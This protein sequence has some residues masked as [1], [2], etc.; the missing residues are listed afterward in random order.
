MDILAHGLWVSV[1]AQALTQ[2]GQPVSTRGAIAWGIAPD[3]VAF[4]PLFGFLLLGVVDGN[5]TWAQFAN[6]ESLG[7]PSLNGHPIF[8][9]TAVLYSLGHS[10]VV[11]AAV[12]AI[13]CW[14][15]RRPCW[16]MGGWGLHILLDI[17]THTHDFYPT[18]FL[19]PLLDWTVNGISWTE[20]WM[21][22]LN[23]IAILMSWAWLA[24][25]SPRHPA[26]GR[27]R[28]KDG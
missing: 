3:L 10:A 20:T 8:P 12:L 28:P 18:P 11:F 9:L 24:T 25:M 6:P 14:W 13:A 21:L 4:T 27:Q 16:E 5:L 15:R 26:R 1:G 19:W 17:P 7:H 23:Y 22:G 2:H